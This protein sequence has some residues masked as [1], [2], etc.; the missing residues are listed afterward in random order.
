MEINPEKI[1]KL[2]TKFLYEKTGY[3]F[4]KSLNYVLSRNIDDLIKEFNEW[5]RKN[6]IELTIT[7][8]MLTRALSKIDKCELPRTVKLLTINDIVNTVKEIERKSG[9]IRERIRKEIEMY[10]KLTPREILKQ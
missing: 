8:E 3:D 9:E 10:R 7:L 1:E 4:H 2:F 6:G 5:L